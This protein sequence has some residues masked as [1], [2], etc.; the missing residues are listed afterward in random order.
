M[1]PG[2]V[3]VIVPMF[4]AARYLRE[5]VESVISQTY[6]DW[7]LLMVD[8]GSTDDTPVVAQTFLAD[9]RIRC[10]RLEKSGVSIARNTGFARTAG[11]FAAF[12]DAD[13][14][15]LPTNLALK[16]DYLQKHPDV[17]FVH[18]DLEVIDDAS[19]RTGR[20]HRGREGQ[21]LDTL[22]LWDGDNVPTPSNVLFRRSLLEQHGLFDP[23][24]STAADQELYFRLASHT[25]VGRIPQ[26]VAL[27]RVHPD[28]MHLKVDLM[29]RDHIAVYRKATELRLF[30]SPWF[31]R[32]CLS[33]LYLILAGSWWHEG[34][35]KPRALRFL[36]RSA[37]TYPPNL[38]RIAYKAMAALTRLFFARVFRR[39][40]RIPEP[41]SRN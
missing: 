6:A 24:F 23:A 41:S 20:V 10:V 8:D 4:N 29:E 16:V 13:D 34:K 19:R 39:G 21:I 40:P 17:G 32:R 7:D 38:G 31:R 28:A 33:N 26:V 37:V 5:T 25:R 11:S 30:K 18:G 35:R 3:S 36:V 27:Y 22:L 1:S 2:H 9:S 15:W 14:V 12:L